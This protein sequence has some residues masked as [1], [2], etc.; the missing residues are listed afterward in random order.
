MPKHRIEGTTNFN[1]W[2]TRIAP[3][4]SKNI[5]LFDLFFNKKYITLVQFDMQTMNISVMRK[6]AMTHEYT[7]IEKG[8]Q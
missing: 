3:D 1:C 2:K 6:K 7:P 5:I 8:K 4:T